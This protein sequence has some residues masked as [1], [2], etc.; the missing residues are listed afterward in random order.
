MKPMN[1]IKLLNE[2]YKHYNVNKGV[3]GIIINTDVE[4]S[5]ILFFNDYNWGDYAV[6]SVKNIDVELCDMEIPDKY[7]KE[8]T[9]YISK[10]KNK[11]FDKN[12]LSVKNLKENDFVELIN[13]KNYKNHSLKVG[14]TGVVVS[15]HISNNYVLVDFSGITPDGKYF[16]G[17]YQI[18]IHD[19]K[20]KN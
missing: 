10:N 13:D 6:V 19:L 7:K 14:D 16:G 5:D 20:L 15:N 18:S 17:T 9:R 12:K 4:K 1:V 8:L 3:Y 2:K 11:I